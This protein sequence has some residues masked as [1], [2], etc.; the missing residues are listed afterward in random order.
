MQWRKWS[1]HG[2][3]DEIYESGGKPQNFEVLSEIQLIFESCSGFH[4]FVSPPF[5]LFCQLPTSTTPLQPPPLEKLHNTSFLHITLLYIYISIF[6]Y[7]WTVT[8]QLRFG[9]GVL[10]IGCRLPPFKDP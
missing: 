6:F 10:P 1:Q 9:V 7:S 2:G 5:H 8:F 4:N 3:F